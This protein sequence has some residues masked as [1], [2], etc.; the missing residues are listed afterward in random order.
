ML[1]YA[2]EWLASGLLCSSGMALTADGHEKSSD[3]L[4]PRETLALIRYYPHHYPP[5]PRFWLAHP[6]VKPALYD[7]LVKSTDTHELS[8]I[9]HLI[10]IVGDERD[11]ARL[12]QT[13]EQ[14]G[15]NNNAA[16][17]QAVLRALALLGDRGIGAAYHAL[18]RM[19][20]PSY[21]SYARQPDAALWD[22]V[23]ALRD[24]N[25]PEFQ[26]MLDDLK[27]ASP[28]EEVRHKLATEFQ[29]L[30]EYRNAKGDALSLYRESKNNRDGLDPWMKLFMVGQNE[31]VRRAVKVFGLYGEMA[32]P[33]LPLLSQRLT[34]ETDAD[35]LEVILIAITEIGAAAKPLAEKIHS[36]MDHQKPSVRAYGALALARI[37]DHSPATKAILTRNL[38]DS[39]PFV[40]LFSITAFGVLSE[41]TDWQ[42]ASKLVGILADSPRDPIHHEYPTRTSTIPFPTSTPEV[43]RMAL[44]HFPEQE[45]PLACAAAF[46]LTRTGTKVPN[47][48]AI[49]ALKAGNRLLMIYTLENAATDW[50]GRT[51]LLGHILPLLG[52]DD[53]PIAVL[54]MQALASIGERSQEVQ[55]AIAAEL[56]KPSVWRQI[57][58]LC[59]LAQLGDRLMLPRVEPFK[60]CENEFIRS[61]AENTIKAINSRGE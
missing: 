32:A 43:I 18:E 55:K 52:T 31:S 45:A 61:E 4:T 37:S 1:K 21:W 35:L 13:L 17:R 46:A 24:S 59:A 23:I 39:S 60:A 58:A 22:V 15:V 7:R 6:D 25:H 53:E 16:A 19:M 50:R 44:A 12:K 10:G 41:K 11:I 36:F 49:A 28:G 40:R 47:D 51:V 42:A 20:T 33:A 48:V 30:V 3:R 14:M 27:N 38:D 29:K 8:M 2:I 56:D 5:Y 57:H 34:K 54:A 26:R 9:G